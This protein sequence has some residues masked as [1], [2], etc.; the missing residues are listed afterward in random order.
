MSQQALSRIAAAVPRPGALQ[1]HWLGPLLCVPA[2]ALVTAFLVVPAALTVH[3]SMTDMSLSTLG[4]V[5]WVG[6]DNYRR[7]LSRPELPRIALNTVLFVSVNLVAFN[8]VLPLTVAALTSAWE[9]RLGR[10]LRT[11]WLL[12]RVTPSVVYALLWVWLTAPAPYGTLNQLLSPLGASGGSWLLSHPWPVLIAADGLVGTSFATVLFSAAIRAVPQELL[13]AA[14][15]DGASYWQTFRYV[16]LPLLRWPMLFVATYQGLSLL[17]SFEFVLLLTNGGPG[18]W[19]TEVWSLYAY[20]QA[21]SYYTGG[22]QM[23]YGAAIASLLVGFGVVA[24]LA[25]LRLF[26]FAQLTAE[27]R[28]RAV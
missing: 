16:I 14:A 13:R 27:P 7:L 21:F 24:S 2:L 6:L 9:E 25:A 17:A 10:F 5:S 23:G 8:I 1:R 15:A 26:R 4:S 20:H 12:P 18:L 3:I 22:L 28:L 19:E 11:L